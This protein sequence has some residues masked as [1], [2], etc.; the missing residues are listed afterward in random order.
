MRKLRRISIALSI[1]LGFCL[2]ENL[3][4]PSVTHIRS[5]YLPE[6]EEFDY[7]FKPEAMARSF[8]ISEGKDTGHIASSATPDGLYFRED[9]QRTQLLLI[10]EPDLGKDLLNLNQGGQLFGYRFWQRNIFSHYTLIYSSRRFQDGIQ[11]AQFNMSLTL[12]FSARFNSRKEKEK[13]NKLME[14]LVQRLSRCEAREHS[15]EES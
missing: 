10:P 5:I 15:N 7:C 11:F 3:A 1:F 9:D 12:P 2:L 13:L 8:L 14:S 4:R 6:T